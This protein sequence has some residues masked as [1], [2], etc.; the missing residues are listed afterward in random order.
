MFDKAPILNSK[1]VFIRIPRTGST[2]LFNSINDNNSS[3]LQLLNHG[4]FYKLEV[5]N[6]FKRCKVQEDFFYFNKNMFKN[7][8]AIVR[9]P[10]N[11]L[12]SYYNHVGP[13]GKGWGGCNDYHNFS[14]WNNFLEA[15]IEPNFK[16]HLPPMKFSLFSMGYDKN[17]HWIPNRYFKLEEPNNINTFLKYYGF[18]PLQKSNISVKLNKKYYTSS[19]VKE[20]N[21]IWEHD[22]KHF[23]YQ[24]E[25]Q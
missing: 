21:K 12:I 2:S 13:R 23:N 7:I 16:W 8:Y 1:N 5:D 22:L 9:N 3:F 24:Y 4:Y 20:L 6:I 18:S 15:Y 14:T 10:F 17:G 11:L 25:G 19:Q